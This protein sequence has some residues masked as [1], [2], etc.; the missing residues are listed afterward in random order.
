MIKYLHL[1]GSK[2]IYTTLFI[3]VMQ[4]LISIK[5]RN[6]FIYSNYPHDYEHFLKKSIKKKRNTIK[7]FEEYIKYNYNNEFIIINE[8]NEIMKNNTYFE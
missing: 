7:L 1:E 2:I 5:K 8:L 4:Q 6:E 3:V